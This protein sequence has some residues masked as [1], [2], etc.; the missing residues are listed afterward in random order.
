MGKRL[1]GEVEV[2]LHVLA[3]DGLLVAASDVVPLDAVPVEVVEHRHARLRLA[4]LPVLPV[5]RLPNTSTVKKNVLKMHFLPHAFDFFLKDHRH[6]IYCT[7][8]CCYKLKWWKGEEE[9]VGG[10]SDISPIACQK[11]EREGGGGLIWKS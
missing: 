2:P 9:E 8:R 1:P 3:D 10:K 6:V 11:K 7:V 5:I 4:A